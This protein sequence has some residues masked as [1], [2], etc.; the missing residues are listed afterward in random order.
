MGV[1]QGSIWEIGVAF[2][3]VCQ[4]SPRFSKNSWKMTFEIP[5]RRAVHGAVI[6]VGD[7][8]GSSTGW[9]MRV[10]IL[11]G[12]H[13]EFSALPSLS[14]SL[15]LYIS[16]SLSLALCLSCSLSRPLSHTLARSLPLAG[17]CGRRGTLPRVHPTCLQGNLGIFLSFYGSEFCYT[18]ALILLVKHMCVVIFIART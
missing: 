14:P 8:G 1:S 9:R 5:P 13:S 16:L 17:M 2:S 7:P 6:P 10:G 3:A 11:R 4:L 15:Y 12:P 18:G